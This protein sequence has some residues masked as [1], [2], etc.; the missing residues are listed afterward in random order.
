LALWKTHF[1]PFGALA[2]A[3]RLTLHIYPIKSGTDRWFIASFN[4]PVSVTNAGARPGVITGLRLRLHFPLI[5]IPENREFFRPVFE[6]DASQAEAIGKNR[7]E[8]IKKLVVGAWMPFTVLPKATVTKHFI[9]EARWD[10]P[11][12][13]AIIDCALEIQSDSGDW[14]DVAD[15]RVPLTPEIWSE[16]TNVG[17]CFTFHANK[18]NHLLNENVPSDLHKYTGSKDKIPEGGFFAHESSLDYQQDENTAE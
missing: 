5:P 3:G 11:V 10:D 4:A 16:L 17:S 18:E 2:V 9:F 14:K 15:W 7:G 1:A 13:Q 12:I 8:W 6:I